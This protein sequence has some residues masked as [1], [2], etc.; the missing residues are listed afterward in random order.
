M[1]ALTVNIADAR[2]YA[3]KLPVVI[4]IEALKLSDRRIG[5]SLSLERA[6]PSGARGAAQFWG[7]EAL[8]R[9][10]AGGGAL[11]LF[12]VMIIVYIL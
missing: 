9:P 5:K 1:G 11:Y 6:P 4:T 12:R 2:Q 7:S 3:L 8:K 10:R